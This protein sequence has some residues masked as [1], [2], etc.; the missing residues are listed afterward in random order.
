MDNSLP[1]FCMRC[2]N[3]V[4][5]GQSFCGKCGTRQSS[6]GEQKNK[7]SKRGKKFI[8]IWSGV[9]AFVLLIAVVVIIVLATGKK[10]RTR[11]VYMIGSDL[12]SDGS[13][14]SLDI[15]EMKD[16]RYDT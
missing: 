7:Q 8:W 15:N 3:P 10:S 13:A 6:N 16:A 5:S 11:M 9:T 4:Q 14:A 1:K 12:E 2:G